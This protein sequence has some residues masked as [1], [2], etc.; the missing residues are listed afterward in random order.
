MSI[1]ERKHCRESDTETN[2]EERD[3]GWKRGGRERGVR[4]KGAEGERERGR[5]EEG[6]GYTEGVGV[7]F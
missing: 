3:K 4:D 5:V 2:N 6:G 1:R 7:R